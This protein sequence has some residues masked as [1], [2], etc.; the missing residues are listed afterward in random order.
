MIVQLTLSAMSMRRTTI[1][2]LEDEDKHGRGPHKLML[3]MAKALLLPAL[4]FMASNEGHSNLT[5]VD[6]QSN[7]VGSLLLGAIKLILPFVH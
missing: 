7:G 3:E 4:P 6:K 5:S 2:R 1:K